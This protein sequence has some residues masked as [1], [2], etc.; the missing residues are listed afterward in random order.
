MWD[1]PILK[2]EAVLTTSSRELPFKR[3]FKSFQGFSVPTS[4][5][6]ATYFKA[7]SK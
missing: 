7:F 3:V 6:V 2:S 5:L 4:S 1:I